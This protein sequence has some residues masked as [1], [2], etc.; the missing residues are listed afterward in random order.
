MVVFLG[1]VAVWVVGFVG[2]VGVWLI[3][4]YPGAFL[5]SALLVG[6]FEPSFGAGHPVHCVHG[7]ETGCGVRSG[8]VVWRGIRC[9]DRSS[10]GWARLWLVT[11]WGLVGR[12]MK[13]A[14]G[15]LARFSPIRNLQTTQLADSSERAFWRG[16]PNRVPSAVI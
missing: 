12:L 9:R 14:C 11:G 2:G 15:Y 5:L 1:V 7:C 16:V 8:H 10:F 3:D 4:G 6:V 13:R